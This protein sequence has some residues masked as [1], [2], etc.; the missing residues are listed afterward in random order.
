MNEDGYIYGVTVE[1][2]GQAENLITKCKLEH[3]AFMIARYIMDGSQCKC[4]P[5][6]RIV[7]L[8]KKECLGA[9]QK[10]TKEL[11]KESSLI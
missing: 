8:E 1:F 7:D 10:D 5:I 3:N 4:K 9:Y 2:E 6:V 11:D